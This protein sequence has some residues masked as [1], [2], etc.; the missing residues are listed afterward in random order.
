ML[1]VQFIGEKT[2]TLY[3]YL[4]TRINYIAME[5]FLCNYTTSSALILVKTCS[6]FFQ[7]HSTFN[8]KLNLSKCIH[9]Y[10]HSKD[11][12]S[13]FIIQSKKCVLVKYSCGRV[14]CC[15]IRKA[16]SCLLDDVIPIK[17]PPCTTR[18]MTSHRHQ[19]CIQSRI[20]EWPIVDQTLY[21]CININRIHH[22]HD[23]AVQ[24]GIW[25]RAKICI[26]F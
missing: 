8:V 13:S 12:V 6:D 3:N 7:Q 2:M 17:P 16:N 22:W 11:M 1:Q 19:W 24:L 26:L 20:A 14:I 18:T 9:L 25:R 4:A 15:F 5:M 23:L 21:A 10:Y